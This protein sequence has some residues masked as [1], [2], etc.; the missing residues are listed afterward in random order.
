MNFLIKGRAQGK[1]FKM[2]ITSEVTGYPI[3]V[4]D[5]KR[6]SFLIDMAKEMGCNIPDP[7]DYKHYKRYTDGRRHDEKIL[8]DDAEEIIREA[9]KETLRV[10]VVAVA[11]TDK[12]FN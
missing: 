5:D 1:T 11:I 8:I 7:I 6:K 12:N 2:I 9:L 4:S 10:E 3:L